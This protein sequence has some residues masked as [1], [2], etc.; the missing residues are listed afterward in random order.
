MGSS[1]S[2]RTAR[3]ITVLVMLWLTSVSPAIT[4]SVNASTSNDSTYAH[5]TLDALI[6]PPPEG[7]TVIDFDDN[8]RP[9]AFS[10]IVPLSE[11]YASL[12]VHFAGTDTSDGGGVLDQCGNFSVSGH[13]PRNFLAFNSGSFRGPE[14]ITFDSA[15]IHFQANAGHSSSG[16]IVF[17]AYDSGSTL[18]DSASIGGSSALATLVL[19][20]TDIRSVVITFTGSVMVLDDLA[21]TTPPP[22]PVPALTQP[23]LLALAGAF[24]L[25]LMLMMRSRVRAA[26]KGLV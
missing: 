24:G 13:S 8:S 3:V 20:G 16:T 4:G 7:A 10:S 26:P 1:V 22:V 18:V 14:T 21:F 5:A 2:T 9:C 11:E 19:Q 23:A 12:G 15:L 17:K 25:L 6:T